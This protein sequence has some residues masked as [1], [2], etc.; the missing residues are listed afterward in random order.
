M[1]MIE[2][3]PIRV[4]ITVEVDGHTF[5]FPQEKPRIRGARYDGRDPSEDGYSRL[6]SLEHRIRTAVD[7]CMGDAVEHTRRFIA[8]AYPVLTKGKA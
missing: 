2:S 1:P 6:D 5:V 7:D 8:T 3:T 4:T